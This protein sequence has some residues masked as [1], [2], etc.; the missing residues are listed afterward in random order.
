MENKLTKTSRLPHIP[1][2]TLEKEAELL[3]K[4]DKYLGILNKEYPELQLLANDEFEVTFALTK[5]EFS[6]LTRE[7]AQYIYDTYKDTTL[8]AKEFFN[9]IANE[10]GI[11]KQH[12][13]V[14]YFNIL[15]TIRYIRKDNRKLYNRVKKDGIISEL[16]LELHVMLTDSLDELFLNK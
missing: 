2:P 16:L 13:K 7:K 6:E 12:D 9:T 1:I 10:E 15:K 3:K 5:A 4:A 11:Q 14:E 8:S